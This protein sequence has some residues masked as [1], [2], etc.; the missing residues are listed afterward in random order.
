MITD[1]N[2]AKRNLNR[3]DDTNNFY[4]ERFLIRVHLEGQIARA[5]QAV[6]RATHQTGC[7]VGRATFGS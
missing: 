4:V 1:G 6:I 2:E 3:F 5:T 7:L